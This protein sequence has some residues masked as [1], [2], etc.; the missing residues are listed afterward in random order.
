MPDH[1]A[2]RT[3]AQKAELA[4][5]RAQG[6][7]AGMEQA[8]LKQSPAAIS[9][10]DAE[11][12]RQTA[13]GIDE[14]DMTIPPS[15]IRADKLWEAQQ[16]NQVVEQDKRKALV[17]EQDKSATVARGK[18]ADW[19]AIVLAGQQLLTQGEL[20]DIQNAGADYGDMAYKKCQAAVERNKPVETEKTAPEKK[21]EQV[22]E[23]DVKAPTQKEILAEVDGDPVA[24]AATQL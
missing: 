23:D 21:P 8:A 12:A 13:E 24:I 7:I 19:D 18:N 9:P 10:L 20:L 11:I 4:L 6:Q 14:V 15:V 1:T 2:L 22:V 5:A 17:G 3:R 16:R